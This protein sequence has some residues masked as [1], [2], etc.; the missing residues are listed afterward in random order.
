MNDN[1]TVRRIMKRSVNKSMG[2]ISHLT[3]AYITEDCS[4]NFFNTLVPCAY[5]KHV[6][7]RDIRNLS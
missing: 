2:I 1:S 5:A 4:G 7:D 3:L 6:V